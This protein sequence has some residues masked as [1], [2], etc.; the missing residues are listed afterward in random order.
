MTERQLQEVK[1]NILDL[2]AHDFPSENLSTLLGLDPTLIAICFIELHL[3]LPSNL[4][5]EEIPPLPHGTPLPSSL[6][7]LPEHLVPRRP[8][9]T[10][11]TLHKSP[12]PIIT[13]ILPTVCT[14]LPPPPEPST[15]PPKPL[16][17]A[18]APFVPKQPNPPGLP[19]STL[20]L[21]LGTT[22]VPM[23]IGSSLVQDA[24]QV[25]EPE[26]AVPPVNAKEAAL[27]RQLLARKSK[28]VL[29]QDAQTSAVPTAPMPSLA[30]L[31]R[32]TE[33]FVVPPPMSMDTIP[34]PPLE[35]RPSSP[36]HSAS[37]TTSI[38]SII[39]TT[40]QTTQSQIDQSIESQSILPP[41]PKEVTL[42]NLRSQSPQV[43]TTDPLINKNGKRLRATD[44]FQ[45]DF[46]PTA[47]S[48][49][50]TTR[51]GSSQ[52]STTLVSVSKRSLTFK[53]VFRAN[54]S[55]SE[56]IALGKKPQTWPSHVIEMS[57]SEDSEDINSET[58]SDTSN[59]MEVIDTAKLEG[60]V[61]GIL[62]GAVASIPS[63]APRTNSP[64]TSISPP[65]TT[66]PSETAHVYEKRLADLA[67][68]K[69][70]IA[71]RQAK[72]KSVHVSQILATTPVSTPLG[73]TAELAARSDDGTPMDDIHMQYD[74]GH[75]ETNSPHALEDHDYIGRRF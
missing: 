30:N 39:S 7:H 56:T 71:K 24:P 64:L 58:Y 2:L 50:V 43:S 6:A 22:A 33:Y 23:Q 28:L 60:D 59:Q 55:L 63:P 4:R 3:R 51:T 61:M 8:P 41:P 49:P 17:A 31:P 57:D 52:D 67:L 42:Q 36:A 29:D 27:R 65:M 1:D 45:D 46:S 62:E 69:A 47:P 44:L 19:L 34:P 35:V 11:Q 70:M 37:R 12:S 54:S 40:I 21:E 73:H 18:A 15:L 9:I 25:P 26:P 14:P 68:L 16:S 48:S 32:N 75:Q 10:P 72:P 53:P 66:T 74:E 13:P 20:H 38:I 5:I